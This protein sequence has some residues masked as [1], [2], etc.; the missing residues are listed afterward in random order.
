MRKGST[1]T[2]VESK[3]SHSSLYI[4]TDEN[5]FKYSNYLLKLHDD[6]KWYSEQDGA[7][8]TTSDLYCEMLYELCEYEKIILPSKQNIRNKNPKEPN[9]IEMLFTEHQLHTALINK[10]ASWELPRLGENARISPLKSGVV[11]YYD[12]AINR[13]LTGYSFTIVKCDDGIKESQQA[14]IE[15]TTALHKFIEENRA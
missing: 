1:M 11:R 2:L 9:T 6:W 3:S 12:K 14:S 4:Q 5:G 15:R 8:V 7:L 13:E 10:F